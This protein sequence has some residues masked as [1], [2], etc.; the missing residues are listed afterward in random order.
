MSQKEVIPLACPGF[1]PKP[2]QNTSPGMQP[3]ASERWP[4]VVPLD[5]E[6]QSVYNEILP[7]TKLVSLSPQK[8]K[9]CINCIF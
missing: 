9:N 8:E 3:E 4:Q 6:E 5:V 2:A 1:Y 7:G